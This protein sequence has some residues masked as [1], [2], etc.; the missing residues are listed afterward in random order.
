MKETY[1]FFAIGHTRNIFLIH[2]KS[3]VSF[4]MA[5]KKCSIRIPLYFNIPSRKAGRPVSVINLKTSFVSSLGHAFKC[6][7]S[8]LSYCLYGVSCVHCAYIG[9]VLC[10]LC[11]VCTVYIDQLRLRGDPLVTHVTSPVHRAQGCTFITL[12]PIAGGKLAPNML[13][14]L[15]I[16]LR[17]GKY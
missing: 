11:V 1:Q 15:Q 8:T 4:L 6:T 16:D 12:P 17:T 2:M 7:L 10:V 9:F 13:Y 5:S 3:Y 14:N